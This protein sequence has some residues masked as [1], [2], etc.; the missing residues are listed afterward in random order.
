MQMAAM[1]EG[2]SNHGKIE[3]VVECPDCGHVIAE[4]LGWSELH[5]LVLS[6]TH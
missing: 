2:C 5:G 1:I 6:T 3:P 4:V